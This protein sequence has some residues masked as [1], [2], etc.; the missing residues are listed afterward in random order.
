MFK[1]DVLANTSERGPVRMGLRKR[2]D[3]RSMVSSLSFSYHLGC[4]L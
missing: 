2:L 3:A 4:I 1:L